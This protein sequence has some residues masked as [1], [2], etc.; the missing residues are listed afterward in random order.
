MAEKQPVEDQIET[1]TKFVT[2][3]SNGQTLNIT[4]QVHLTITDG[5]VLNY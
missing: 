3:T 1:L 5:N 4:F 2:R